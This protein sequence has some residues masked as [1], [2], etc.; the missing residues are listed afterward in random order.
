MSR[1]REYIITFFS[2]FILVFAILFATGTITSGWHL[3]DDH[4]FVRYSLSMKEGS[5]LS[6][7][8]NVLRVDFASRFRPLYHVLRVSMV[9]VLGTNLIAWSVLKAG[10]TVLAMFLLYLCARQLKCNIFLA[11]LFSLTVMVGP[12]SVVWWKLGPQECVGMIFLRR[13]S[14]F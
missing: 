9:A 4:E 12:Q 3:V 5:W 10:E 8:Q 11:V 14:C 1:K 7:L 2:F 13:A 6:C